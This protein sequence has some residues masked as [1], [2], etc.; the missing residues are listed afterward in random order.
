MA[1]AYSISAPAASRPDRRAWA[2]AGLALVSGWTLYAL[3]P[4]RAKAAALLSAVLP[5]PAN[6]SFGELRARRGEINGQTVLYVEGA[7]RNVGAK[8]QKTPTLKIALIG[9]DGRP[10]YTWKAKPAKAVLEPGRDASYQTRLL[11]PPE[12]FKSIAVSAED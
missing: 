9:A 11:A 1:N 10:V 5:A 6:V 12:T 4:A 8:P 2:V 7:L 3:P